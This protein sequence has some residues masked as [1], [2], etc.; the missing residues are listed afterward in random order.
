MQQ[1]DEAFFPTGRE[2]INSDLLRHVTKADL[3][4]LWQDSEKEL[5]V[6]L[7]QAESQRD[8][9]IRQVSKASRD[10]HTLTEGSSED[11]D[12][13]SMEDPLGEAKKPYGAVSRLD[14]DAGDKPRPAR[15]KSRERQADEMRHKNSRRD[16]S[17]TPRKKKR[18]RSKSHDYL[19]TRRSS[20]SLEEKKTYPKSEERVTPRK[21]SSRRKRDVSQ[22]RRT[23]SEEG[24]SLQRQRTIVHRSVEGAIDNTSLVDPPGEYCS[25]PLPLLRSLHQQTKSDA[26]RNYAFLQSLT[27]ERRDEGLPHDTYGDQIHLKT[28]CREVK[29]RACES[30][31]QVEEENRLKKSDDEK[32]SIR[33]RR[34]AHH[35]AG[36]HGEAQARRPRERHPSRELYEGL[37]KRESSLQRDPRQSLPRRPYDREVRD[38]SSPY[39]GSHRHQQPQQQQQHSGRRHTT[40]DSSSDQEETYYS[41]TPSLEPGPAREAH[42]RRQPPQHPPYPRGYEGRR[43]GD[44]M[45][46]RRSSERK[47]FRDVREPP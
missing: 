8:E 3:W 37:H 9:L 13:K 1:F 4:Q 16:S 7:R 26:G 23:M 17:T 24:P 21:H 11:W 46:D 38:H 43:P 18:Q 41:A 15:R 20:E 19:E 39:S 14:E 45:E 29:G 35:G 47:P 44:R 2:R 30:D 5:R 33:R 6:R 22:D 32:L 40:Y 10:H 42:G 12:T 34:A 36:G 25:T 31:D 28:F 27:P